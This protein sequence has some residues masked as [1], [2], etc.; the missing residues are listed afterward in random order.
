M[1]TVQRRLVLGGALVA[2]AAVMGWAYHLSLVPAT[3]PDHDHG[4]LNLDAGGRL[5]VETRSGKERNLVGRP[6]RVLVVHF[7]RLDAPEAAPELAALFAFQKGLAGRRDVEILSIARADTFATLDAWLAKHGLVPPVPES[8]VLDPAGDTTERL[9]SKRPVETMVFGPDGKLSSQA[10]GRLD[11]ENEAPS[12]I[13]QA[14][15][16]TTI[17]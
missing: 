12:R 6:E 16:G 15:A 2:A 7:F 3:H 5:M 4:I 8:L 9:N 1:K 13:A 14:Q 11:W 10:R 17:E